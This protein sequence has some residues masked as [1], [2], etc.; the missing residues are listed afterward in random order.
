MLVVRHL[1]HGHPCYIRHTNG[2]YKR[3][4][5]L[6]EKYIGKDRRDVRV[7]SD[8]ILFVFIYAHL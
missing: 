7:V 3:R 8:V 5:K 2:K 4:K 1:Q 6:E